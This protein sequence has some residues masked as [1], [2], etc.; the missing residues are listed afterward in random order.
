MYEIWYTASI[1]TNDL[2]YRVGLQPDSTC[3]GGSAY[4]SK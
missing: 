1:T 2:F 3:D 4:F